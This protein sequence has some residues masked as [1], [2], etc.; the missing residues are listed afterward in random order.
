MDMA[1]ILDLFFLQAFLATSDTM[2]QFE[3]SYWSLSENRDSVTSCFSPKQATCACVESKRLL[4]CMLTSTYD[5]GKWYASSVTAS[6]TKMSCSL[7]IVYLTP[8]HSTDCAFPMELYT[9][10][11]YWITGW[12]LF[13]MVLEVTE[14]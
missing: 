2:G 6:L 13:Q 14:I 10:T 9:L 4:S 1:N 12:K 5:T 8:F 11:H 7:L 3:G